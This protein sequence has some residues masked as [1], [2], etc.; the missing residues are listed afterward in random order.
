LFDGVGLVEDVADALHDLALPA[1]R[2]V[3]VGVDAG[4]S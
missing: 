3:E 2:G 4:V 1:G